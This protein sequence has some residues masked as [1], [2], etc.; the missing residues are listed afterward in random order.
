[1]PV[2]LMRNLDSKRGLCN[3]TRLL[4]RA[5]YN[6]R[7]LEASIITPCP[8]CLDTVFILCITLTPRE[9]FFLFSWPRRQFPV[10]I[11]FAMTIYKSQGQTLKHAGIYL[12]KECYYHGQFYV[13]CSRIGNPEHLRIY[14]P[15]SNSDTCVGKFCVQ[16][17][18]ELS[19]ALFAIQ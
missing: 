11:S 19:T 10:A 14:Q 15:N 12:N 8:F 17:S 7:L 4:I 3:R 1:M 9:E 16:R 18:T 2:T 5:V 6:N 13:A